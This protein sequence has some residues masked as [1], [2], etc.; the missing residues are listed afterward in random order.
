M[1]AVVRALLGL[2]IGVALAAPLATQSA[3]GAAPARQADAEAMA[4][5]MA[6]AQQGPPVAGPADGVLDQTAGRITLASS[7]VSLRDFYARVRFT[8]PT[9]TGG[10]TWDYGLGFRDTGTGDQYRLI[11]ASDSIWFLGLR[12]DLAGSGSPIPGYDP[13]P[14][15][16]NA[17][18]FVASG[19]QGFFAVNGQ[20]VAT[21]DLSAIT[22][23]GDVW[24]ATAFLDL[25]TVEGARTPYAGF[26]VWSLDA[27]PATPA[28]G[29]TPLATPE[30]AADAAELARLREQARAG[31]SLAGP[32]NGQLVQQ[33]GEAAV[34]A[35]GVDAADFYARARFAGPA[36]TGQAGW[37]YGF[38]FRDQG[39]EEYRLV[40]DSTGTWYLSVGPE[41]AFAAGPAPS[42]NLA[43]GGVNTL[44]LAVAGD[45][46][47]FAVNG[48]F[49][50][51]LDLS[52]I[53]GGGDVA[54]GTAFFAESSAPGAVTRFRDFQVW[55]LAEPVTAA[56]TPV[57]EPEPTATPAA[58]PDLA[59][60]APRVIRLG[61]R[62]GSGVSGLAVLLPV[63]GQTG[64]EV[65]VI[66]ATGDE[67][68]EIVR[69]TCDQLEGEAAAS[70]SPLEAGIRSRT[71]VDVSPEELLGS[72]HV[73]LLRRSAGD[74]ATIVACGE[75]VGS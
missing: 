50:A 6:R 14:G 17:I 48:E 25:N 22:A 66:G 53:A 41:L 56:A 8:N 73:I 19:G 52:A 64:V 58:G 37:D 46:G 5:L 33:G 1:A 65:T 35:A 28:A 24:V 15:A 10:A 62:G 11:L 42:L 54:I 49:V 34:I 13:T 45:V 72:P 44:E 7:G 71:L 60:G 43:P 29:G 18:D 55:P 51:R 59:E 4:E 36:D 2:A 16:E 3:A 12:L 67:L 69:G 26:A 38:V 68:V 61:E 30:P 23:P 40:V 47:Y 32:R 27:Q 9:D 70:L 31:E 21:L 57:A 39:D 63:D 75:V 74:P 20:Y